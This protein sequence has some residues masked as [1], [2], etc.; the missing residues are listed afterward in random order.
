[1]LL[2]EDVAEDAAEVDEDGGTPWGPPRSAWRWAFIW[3]NACWAACM[4][5]LLSAEASCDRGLPCLF[6]SAA[7]FGSD[8]ASLAN[9]ACALLRLPDCI[10]WSSACMS[11][12]VCRHEPVLLVAGALWV[13]E[14]C[15]PKMNS[16]GRGSVVRFAG[17]HAR[18][19]SPL[20]SSLPAE[21]GSV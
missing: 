7:P 9:A 5:P 8:C 12:L 4:L 17:L 6:R 21:S 18:R 19:P 3:V 14:I 1:M 13:E 11:C 16:S 10:A 20:F 15:M 2:D